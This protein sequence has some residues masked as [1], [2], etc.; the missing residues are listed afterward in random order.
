M[1]KYCLAL[2]ILLYAFAAKAQLI[3]DR[4]NG[5]I[6]IGADL[7]TDISTKDYDN[8]SL[9]NIN[10]GADIYLTCNFPM[11]KS[12]HTFSIGVGYTAHN[13]YLKNYHIENPYDETVVLIPNEYDCKRNKI[14]TNYFDIPMEINFRIANKFKISAG[15]KLDILLSGRYKYVGAMDDS[16]QVYRVRYNRIKSLK[17]YVGTATFRVAYRCLNLFAAYQFTPTYDDD[18]GPEMLPFSIGIGIRA[19]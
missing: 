7:F 2:I 16:G 8:M 17:K 10:P 15:A 19:F 1:K 13:F 4:T 6:T 9:R 18:K 12:K 3:A 5:K 14:N 11:G